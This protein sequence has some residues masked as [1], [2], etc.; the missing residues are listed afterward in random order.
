MVSLTSIGQALRACKFG[1]AI[2]RM[3]RAGRRSLTAG[4]Q[5]VPTGAAVGALAAVTGL[6]QIKFMSTVV[7]APLNCALSVIVP[8]TAS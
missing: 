8:A 2:M 1:A 6:D 4:I 3:C 5:T 7:P